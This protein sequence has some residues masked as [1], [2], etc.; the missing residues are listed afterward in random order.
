MGRTLKISEA[1]RTLFELVD[2]VTSGAETV[3]WI[4]HRDRAEGAALVSA[5]YLRSLHTRIEELRR[6]TRPFKLAGSMRLVG[7]EAD[8][9]AD[10]EALR[11]A[12]REAIHAKFQ[13]L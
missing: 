9:E 10:L 7:S 1:R 2:E 11:R 8:L 5:R 3:V 12:Q 6:Q 13:D 4:E